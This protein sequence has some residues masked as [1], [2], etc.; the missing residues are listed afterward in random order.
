MRVMEKDQGMEK[1]DKEGDGE[2]SVEEEETG[3][4]Q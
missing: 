2:E 1:K 4:E 3:G